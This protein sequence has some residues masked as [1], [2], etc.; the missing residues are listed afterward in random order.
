M[1]KSSDEQEVKLPTFK[2]LCAGKFL[3]DY[4]YYVDGFWFPN[5]FKQLTILTK[6][7][8][9][10][11]DS[12]SNAVQELISQIHTGIANGHVYKIMVSRGDNPEWEIIRDEDYEAEYRFIGEDTGAFVKGTLKAVIP[13]SAKPGKK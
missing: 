5:Q 8:R 13:K 9:I 10:G 7:F 2:Q 3:F 4:Q 11:L 1:F 12:R 6:E